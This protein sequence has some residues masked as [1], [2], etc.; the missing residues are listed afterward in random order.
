M[1]RRAMLIARL[2]VVSAAYERILDILPS[3]PRLSGEITPH[4]TEPAAA[5]QDTSCEPP[6][7]SKEE[8]PS[9]S[10]RSARAPHQNV[11]H[12]ASKTA[13]E[14][15]GRGGDG[16]EDLALSGAAAA[17]REF[18]ILLWALR[19]VAA[20]VIQQEVRGYARRQ[21][22]RRRL[23]ERSRGEVGNVGE[24][25]M[26]IVLADVTNT[27]EASRGSSCGSVAGG[28]GVGAGSG[29]ASG[30]RL[31]PVHV[32]AASFGVKGGTDEVATPNTLTLPVGEEQ[33]FL[34]RPEA[35]RSPDVSTAST[36]YQERDTDGD[37][38]GDV[39]GHFGDLFS[40]GAGTTTRSEGPQGTRSSIFGGGAG[41]GGSQERFCAGKAHCNSARAR[42]VG[43]P[44]LPSEES[45]RR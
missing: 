17:E 14:V 39:P 44:L 30:Q 16:H 23:L 15:V 3:L 22:G 19:D 34:F 29:S 32:R 5:S 11:Q 35:V 36:R 6:Q 18:R 24:D 21:I 1:G 26:P 25:M 20:R 12:V 28:P 9:A 43:L 41:S 45:K 42:D 8:A 33:S 7:P 31:R 38:R 4:L 37:E 10:I 40:K 13:I 2:K 27:Q